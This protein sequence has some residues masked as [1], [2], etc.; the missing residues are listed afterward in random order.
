[1]VYELRHSF[2]SGATEEFD[3]LSSTSFPKSNLLRSLENFGSILQVLRTEI[4][5]SNFLLNVVLVISLSTPPE[6]R[7][8]GVSCRPFLGTYPTLRN[9]ST[10]DV[11]SIINLY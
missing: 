7:E 10:G 1:M 3:A 9:I 4:K 2:S 11:L 5:T 6:R 8:A